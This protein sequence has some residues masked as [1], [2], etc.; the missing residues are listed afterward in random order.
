[1][2]LDRKDKDPVVVQPTRMDVSFISPSLVLDS[3]GSPREKPVFYLIWN[4][5]EVGSNTSEVIAQEQNRLIYQRS[6]SRLAKSKIPSSIFFYV[7]ANRWFDTD[8][9]LVFQYQV[10]Q[11]RKSLI[12]MTIYLGF[13]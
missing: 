11:S 3:Y 13:S 5:E 1:M 2:S 10:L 12:E 7:T 8:L 6:I 4:P 9:G